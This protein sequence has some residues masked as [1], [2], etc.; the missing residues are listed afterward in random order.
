MQNVH[1][2]GLDGRTQLYR[3][4]DGGIQ[5]YKTIDHLYCAL[6]NTSL[7]RQSVMLHSSTMRIGD[8][9]YFDLN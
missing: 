6:I 7:A 1:D 2:V 8:F 9:F 3:T 4:A 5:L